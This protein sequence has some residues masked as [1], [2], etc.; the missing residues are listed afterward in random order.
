[1]KQLLIS[2]QTANIDLETE[3]L[4]DDMERSVVSYVCV[5]WI[6]KNKSENIG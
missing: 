4:E 3:M 6:I 2:H 5:K 1:M